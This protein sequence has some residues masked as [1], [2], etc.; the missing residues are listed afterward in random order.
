MAELHRFDSCG[1]QTRKETCCGKGA[2]ID[3]SGGKTHGRLWLVEVM[4]EVDD[5]IAF[6]KAMG[7]ATAYCREVE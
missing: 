2:R 5:V 1:T 7:N 6:A 3:T 4:Q